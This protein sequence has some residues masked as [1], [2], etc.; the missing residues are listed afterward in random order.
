MEI[1]AVDQMTCGGSDA[2]LLAIVH[3]LFASRKFLLPSRFDLDEHDGGSVLHDQ[4]NLT[5]FRPV[6]AA[7]VSVAFLS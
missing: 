5:L 1:A 3:N 2:S 7:E 6:V 4:I